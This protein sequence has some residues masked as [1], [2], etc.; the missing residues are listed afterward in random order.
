MQKTFLAITAAL[1]MMGTTAFAGHG[2]GFH[3]AGGGVHAGGFHGGVSHFNGDRDRFHGGFRGGRGYGV[4]YG[5]CVVIGPL[6]LPC[7]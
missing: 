4:P 3:G 5:P 1:L 2:G 6:W 7:Q